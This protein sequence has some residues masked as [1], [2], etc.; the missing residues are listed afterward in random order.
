MSNDETGE[1]IVH[2]DPEAEERRKLP[3]LE[4]SDTKLSGTQESMECG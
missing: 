1:F 4:V 2:R 3:G